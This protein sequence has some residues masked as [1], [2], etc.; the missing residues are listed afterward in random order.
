MELDCKDIKVS[1][2]ISAQKTFPT[3]FSFSLTFLSCFF[4][5]TIINERVQLRHFNENLFALLFSLRIL[6]LLMFLLLFADATIIIIIFIDVEKAWFSYKR[7]N[8]VSVALRFF[9]SFR[10]SSTNVSDSTTLLDFFYLFLKS[11]NIDSL[12]V[13]SV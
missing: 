8:N 5:S 13:R 12:H 6:A 4:L 11:N 1:D 9:F 2:F 10:F 7:I 3:H